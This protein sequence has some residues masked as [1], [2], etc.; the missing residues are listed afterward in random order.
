MTLL[1]LHP[2]AMPFR[3]GQI[4]P[5]R[6]GGVPPKLYLEVID[7]TGQGQ[8]FC[9]APRRE[10]R[11][12]HPMEAAWAIFERPAEEVVE[13]RDLIAGI[14][15]RIK[16]EGCQRPLILVARY[17]GAGRLACREWSEGLKA[18]GEPFTVILGAWEYNCLVLESAGQLPPSLYLSWARDLFVDKAGALL[19]TVDKFDAL[20]LSPSPKG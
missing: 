13:S 14:L 12:E 3:A 20:I 7:D 6:R 11:S 15:T 18:R 17:A 8:R 16:A 10:I 19:H 1:C 9:L 2:S 4:Y 5:A